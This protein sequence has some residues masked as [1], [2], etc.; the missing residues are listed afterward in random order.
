VSIETSTPFVRPDG[1]RAVG[2]KTLL[3]AEQQGRVAE[4][5]I[6]G[7]RAEVRVVKDGLTR[8]SGVTVGGGSALAKSVK[9]ARIADN[10]DVFDFELTREQVQAIDALEAGVRGGPEP[11]S[12]ALETYGR[13]IPRS[14]TACGSRDWAGSSRSAH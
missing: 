14:V 9:P 4:L 6:D 1:L 12:I 11:Q 3:Q 13:P 2:P 10:L 8:A 5:T 7:N